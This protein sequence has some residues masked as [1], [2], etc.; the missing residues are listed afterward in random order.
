M[1]LNNSGVNHLICLGS[2]EL[3]NRIVVHL[4]VDAD[5]NISQTQENSMQ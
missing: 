1:T 3:Q 4:Y 2:G 5:G